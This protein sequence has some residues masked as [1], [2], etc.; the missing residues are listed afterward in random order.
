MPDRLRRFR[1]LVAHTGILFG[2][3][4]D[5]RCRAS[6]APRLH[7]P[8]PLFTS[9]GQLHFAALYC[10]DLARLADRDPSHRACGDRTRESTVLS[11]AA[12][13]PDTMQWQFGKKVV[14]CLARD[15]LGVDT[16]QYCQL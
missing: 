10:R 4:P 15:D 3:H 13:Y 8:I 5:S 9:P 2:R 12:V 11:Y 6:S 16:G 1:L 7:C 14:W